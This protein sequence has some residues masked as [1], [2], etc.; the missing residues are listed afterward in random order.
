MKENGIVFFVEGD[1]EVEFYKALISNIH[2]ENGKFNVNKILYENIKGITNYK[3]KINRIF[4]GRII[5]KYPNMGFTVFLCYDTDVFDFSQHPKIN[6]KEVE[7]SLKKYGAKEVIHIKAVKSI[8]DWFLM[9]KE[10]VLT[11][12]KLP[13]DFK[14]KGKSNGQVLLKELFKK[15]NRVYIK[16]QKCEGFI[17]CLD[18][19]VIEEGIKEEI[20]GIYTALGIKQKI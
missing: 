9:D 7:K 16:G 10:G 15:A 4:S 11:Y 19:S 1:T 17:S 2:K 6:W 18:M 14:I 8:E 12:L 13:K 5:N 3:N 20:K